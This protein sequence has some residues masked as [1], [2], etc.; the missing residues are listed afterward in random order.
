MQ[1][2]DEC[3]FIKLPARS[4]NLAVVR[5]AVGNVARQFGMTDEG[6]ADLQIVVTEACSNVVIHAYGDRPQGSLEVEAECEA[7]EFGVVVRDYGS[8][9]RAPALAETDSLRLGLALISTLSS[10]F[11]VSEHQD[12]GT[13]VSVRLPFLASG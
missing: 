1:G 6:V 12:G 2:G 5:H 3:L 7:A 10:S 8:G 4:E 13:E 9:F 11:D